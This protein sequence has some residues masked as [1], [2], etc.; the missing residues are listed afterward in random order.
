MMKATIPARRFK[1]RAASRQGVTEEA[2]MAVGIL[3]AAIRV[4]VTRVAVATPVGG[5]PAEDT[6]AAVIPAEAAI[7]EVAG[8]AG[9]ADGTRRR[10]KSWSSLSALPV[11]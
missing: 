6:R 11:R 7:P 9:I 3:V 1:T 4:V 5:I 2:A 10:T 8:D